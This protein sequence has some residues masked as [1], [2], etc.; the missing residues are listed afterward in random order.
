MISVIK[1]C[2]TL[3]DDNLNKKKVT[4]LFYEVVNRTVTRFPRV[5]TKFSQ[6]VV[7][8]NEKR[9]RNLSDLFVIVTGVGFV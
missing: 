7:K 5:L 2:L 8:S 1:S 3:I 4:L 9:T 6:S